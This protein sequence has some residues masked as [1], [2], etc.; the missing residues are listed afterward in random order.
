MSIPIA[1][2]RRSNLL[3]RALFRF[4]CTRL[5]I[6]VCRCH[7]SVSGN[8]VVCSFQM[9]LFLWEYLKFPF[10]HKHLPDDCSYTHI[11]SSAFF[12]HHGTW[13]RALLFCRLNNNLLLLFLS[14]VFRNRAF[15]FRKRSSALV[16]FPTNRWNWWFPS[17]R[18]QTALQMKKGD[19][20]KISR[21]F[22]WNEIILSHS[23]ALDG[24]VPL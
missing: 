13:S 12:R 7:K 3:F 17:G 14:R 11:W 5:R 16:S 21:W 1:R 23:Q 4:R 19:T 18:M 24:S 8:L 15:I 6:L 2:F 9:F 22:D 10:W 20:E